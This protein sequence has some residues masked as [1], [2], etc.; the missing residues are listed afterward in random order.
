LLTDLVMPGMPGLELARR[1]VHLRPEMKVVCMSGYSDAADPEAGEL[2]AA[3]ALLE[4]PFT[5]EALVSCVRRVL[6]GSDP[7]A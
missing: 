5:A 2:D 3:L 1:L 6:D 4:K 7:S